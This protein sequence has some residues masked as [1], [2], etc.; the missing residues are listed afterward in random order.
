MIH[1]FF[2]A[3][4]YIN[5]KLQTPSKYQ[6]FNIYLIC[7]KSQIEA[8]MQIRPNNQLFYNIL[9]KEHLMDKIID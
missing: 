7:I 2:I 6:V 5:K 9:N 4:V 3:P 1:T 8:V